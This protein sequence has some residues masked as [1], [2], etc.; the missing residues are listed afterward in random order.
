[1]SVAR[2]VRRLSERAD[3]VP[4]DLSAAGAPFLRPGGVPPFPEP[5]R[6]LDGFSALLSPDAGLAADAVAPQMPMI[7]SPTSPMMCDV[8]SKLG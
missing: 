8:E 7:S 5:R 3:R 2:R 6:Y 1:M 4:S